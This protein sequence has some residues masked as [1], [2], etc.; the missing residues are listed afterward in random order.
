M[1]LLETV[2][3]FA[4]TNMTEPVREALNMRGFSD[5]Q[6]DLFRIGHIDTQ[7]PELD[8]ASEFL[9]WCW[10]GRKLDDV[11]C[12]PLTNTLGQI[13]GLQFRHVERERSGYM[14][15][16]PVGDE[17]VLFG[18]HEAMAH[19]WETGTILT[20][21]GVFDLA[22]VQ[23][24]EPA[25]VATLHAR[26]SKQLVAVLRRV[27]TEVWVGFDM[28]EAGRS[29]CE[30]FAHFHGDEFRVKPINWRRLDLPDGGRTKDPNELWEAW[31]DTKFGVFLKRQQD[32][33]YTES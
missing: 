31:G 26:I 32:P 20:V 22:P 11:Y 30:K 5:E 7:L 28:D 8:D 16:I 15:F 4:S 19:I 23:R 13:K 14:D 29:G 24:Q 12:F 18:L 33:Y 6:I 27:V 9:D 21:E 25:T 17:A 3:N 1:Q 2:A 10:Q